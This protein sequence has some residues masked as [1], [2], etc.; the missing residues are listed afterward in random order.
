LDAIIAKQLPHVWLPD[1][2]TRLA[3]RGRSAIENITSGHDD[4]LIE[5]MSVVAAWISDAEPPPVAGNLGWSP[6]KLGRVRIGAL[7][8]AAGISRLDA[9]NSSVDAV[10]RC[11][12]DVAAAATS[13]ERW[14]AD[15][16]DR[17]VLVNDR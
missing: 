9:H 7:T 13:I 8:I 16:D 17:L 2:L 6:E 12:V 15:R 11:F 14:S 3:Q 10:A 1:E 5:R 4:R